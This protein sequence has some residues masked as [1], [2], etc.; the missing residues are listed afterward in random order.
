MAG[1]RTAG[2]RGGT[3]R[4]RTGHRQVGSPRRRPT[5]WPSRASKTLVLNDSSQARTNEIPCK[6]VEEKNVRLTTGSSAVYPWDHDRSS[7]L[8]ADQFAVAYL[9]L[10][11]FARARHVREYT[12]IYIYIYLSRPKP[13]HTT[14][15]SG[16]AG[17]GRSGA[18]LDAGGFVRPGDTQPSCPPGN[19]NQLSLTALRKHAQTKSYVNC[20]GNKTR[21]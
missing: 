5:L 21:G 19:R 16:R 14:C 2:R 11:V 3:G 8:A 15:D 6:P 7:F 17:V 10:Y 9:S 20:W 13:G 12:Y 4:G 18:G 1:R